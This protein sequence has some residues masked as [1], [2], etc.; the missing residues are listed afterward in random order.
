LQQPAGISK[1]DIIFVTGIAADSL[2]WPPCFI[3]AFSEA[4]YRVV[5]FDNRATGMSD[6]MEDYPHWRYNFTEMAGDV[7]AGLDKL[8]IREAHVI[9]VSMGGMIAQQM[10]ILNPGRVKS[11]TSIMSSA[12]INDPDLPHVPWKTV[13]NVIRIS[14]RYG[15]IKSERNIINLHLGIWQLF[16]NEAFSPAEVKS[17]SERVFFNLGRG[18]ASIPWLSLSSFMQ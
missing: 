2:W 11:L 13:W 15:I 8:K 14:C 10:A 7:I 16:K 6:W 1:G 4:G 9:G 3:K 5:L 18:E 12:N 17:I